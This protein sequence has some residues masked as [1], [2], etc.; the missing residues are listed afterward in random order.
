M[1]GLCLSFTREGDAPAGCRAGRAKR[2][3]PLWG[4]SQSPACRNGDWVAD[5]RR[6]LILRAQRVLK[7][8][9]VIRKRR[10]NHAV[11]PPLVRSAA[12]EAASPARDARAPRP[13]LS[14]RIARRAQR[15]FHPLWK[16]GTPRPTGRKKQG[17]T[18]RPAPKLRLIQSLPVPRIPLLQRKLRPLPPCSCARSR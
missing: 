4:G 9:K 12:A 3:A 13:A 16:V 15:H 14:R 7:E 6:H 1:Y 17:Q 8:G 10:G 5:G 18:F 2:A 11:P